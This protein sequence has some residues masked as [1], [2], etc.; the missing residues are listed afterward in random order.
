M[1]NKTNQQKIQSLYNLLDAWA[2]VNGLL[3]SNFQDLVYETYKKIR[4][5]EIEEEQ[6]EHNKEIK[7]IERLTKN[8]K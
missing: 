3:T 8:N 4:E 1:E 2:D 5:L 7:L 6:K